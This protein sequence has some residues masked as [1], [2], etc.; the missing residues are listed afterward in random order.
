M[1]AF[2][3]VIR[4]ASANYRK[5][6]TVENKMTY[7]LPP[8][9]TV[10]GAL[11][12]A[13]NYTEY[14]EM[15]LSIQGHYESMHREPYT[16]YSFLDTLENDRGILVW[17]PNAKFFSNAYIKVAQSKKSQGSDFRENIAIQVYD[18][19]LIEE[20]CRLKDLNDSITEF[21]KKRLAP[22]LSLIKKRKKSLKEKKKIRKQA[23]QDCD[24]VISR[25][26]EIKEIEKEIKERFEKYKYENYTEPI[27]HFRNLVKSVKY[28]EILNNIELIIHVQ[29]SDE[30]L[31]DLEEHWVDIK[32]IGRSEDMVDV[33]EAKIVELLEEGK[34]NVRGMYP[35]YLNVDA[36]CTDPFDDSEYRKIY[37]KSIKG[38]SIR[39]T[40][41]Y[42]NKNYTISPETGKRIFEKKRVVYT[43]RYG[44]DEL[45]KGIYLDIDEQSGKKYIVNFI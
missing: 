40:K 2:R 30:V 41:Y 11:H 6:E 24:S 45:G 26:K 21:K 37:P 13:C 42:L 32:S 17:L 36:I 8:L 10:I 7:P 43:S 22:L 3:L 14:K 35:A 27:S 31:H 38:S 28:Y 18:K 4:Q 33:Q 12:K 19:S 1:K 9:S 23:G 25:E 44:I 5:P 34:Y 20:Y 16:D 29:A 15:N 39:G